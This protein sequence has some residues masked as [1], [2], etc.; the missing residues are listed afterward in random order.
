MNLSPL[1]S[2]RSRLH[3]TVLLACLLLSSV[4]CAQSGGAT[5]PRSAASA[6]LI[7]RYPAGSIQSIEVADQAL[8]E[9]GRARAG[10]ETLFAEDQRA[11]YPKFFTTSCLEDAKE[12]RRHTLAQ[13]RPIEVEAGGFKRH[14]RVLERD[15][16]L[17]EKRAKDESEAPQRDKERQE[18]EAVIM[19]KSM[20]RTSVNKLGRDADDTSQ[21]NV[22]KRIASHEAKL[23]REETEEIANTKKRAENIEA[24]E[25]KVHDTENR[26]REIANRKSGKQ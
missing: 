17:A 2:Y 20:D 5:E 7:K 1:I 25:K 10:I 21:L 9:A 23:Q 24:Y 3:L 13:V 19:K 6:N 14:A 4:A 22:S 11:C 12:R 8:E 26:Q 16:D 18:K 15:K